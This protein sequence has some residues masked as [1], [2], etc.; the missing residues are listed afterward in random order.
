M[1]LDDTQRAPDRPLPCPQ[2]RYDLRG[3]LDDPVT[4]PECGTRTGRH[5]LTGGAGADRAGRGRALQQ[6][7]D[8][9]TAGTVL[10]AA[11]A[12]ICL[13]APAGACTCLA[14]AGPLALA[15]VSAVPAARVMRQF[16]ESKH[17][18]HGELA[19]YLAW[20]AGLAAF[21]L[22]VPWLGLAAWWQV[23][24]RLAWLGESQA[25]ACTL[26]AALMAA[27]YVLG[28][29]RLATWRRARERQMARLMQMAQADWPASES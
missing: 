27:L 14:L 28:L 25:A 12:G 26:L 5:E 21:L 9:A 4:C 6:A 17:G 13:V 15:G 23:S 10:A 24:I 3:S 16:A 19:G 11:S 20:T 8:T 29:R 7:L 18:W 1:S 22:F 2:C